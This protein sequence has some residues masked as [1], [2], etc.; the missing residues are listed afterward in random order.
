MLMVAAVWLRRRHQVW[1]TTSTRRMRLTRVERT[2]AGWAR[3]NPGAGSSPPAVTTASSRSLIVVLLT[4]CGVADAT[5]PGVWVRAHPPAVGE[6][7]SRR[8]H[9][10]R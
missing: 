7:W 8:R 2:A 3:S 4:L 6:R 5:Q 10:V 1:R 9:G